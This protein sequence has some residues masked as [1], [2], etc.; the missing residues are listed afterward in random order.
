MNQMAIDFV[1]LAANFDEGFAIVLVKP[2]DHCVEP[3]QR[4]A[5]RN[6][7]LLVT[8]RV[9]FRVGEFLFERFFAGLRLIDVFLQN[10]ESLSGFVI[11]ERA[12]GILEFRFPQRQ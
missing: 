8:V 5:K 11:C 10:V 6:L 2:D 4:S 3:S 9:F 1:E 12:F 7:K